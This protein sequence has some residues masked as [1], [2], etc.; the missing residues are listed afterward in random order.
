MNYNNINA[1]SADL[2]NRAKM[3]YLSIL[4]TSEEREQAESYFSMISGISL[5]GN[6]FRFSV[7]NKFAA[8]FLT[9]NYSDKLKNAFDLAGGSKD[10][11]LQFVS[12]PNSSRT[13]INNIPV[14]KTQIPV[15]NTSASE[16]KAETKKIPTPFISTLP[17]EEN[18]T[19]EEFVQGSSNS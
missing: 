17:L 11:Q 3:I 10:L 12:D 9:E 7:S 15:N 2:W 4:R 14:I 6:I 13:I 1:D 8:D 5:E 19:F 16:N 18:F